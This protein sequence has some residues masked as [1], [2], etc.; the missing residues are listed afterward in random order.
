MYSSQARCKLP[1]R[2][3]RLRV[4]GD[5]AETGYPP[6]ETRLLELILELWR[7]KERSDEG[8]RSGAKSR[9]NRGGI[10]TDSH[11]WYGDY[12][13]SYDQSAGRRLTAPCC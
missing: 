8:G 5:L 7:D 9:I 10:A 1:I 13:A 6:E 11:F 4:A 3:S 12:V 2:P